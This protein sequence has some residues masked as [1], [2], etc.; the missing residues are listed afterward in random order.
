MCCSVLQ[1][2]AVQITSDI[3]Y[4][5]CCSQVLQ[6]VA[7]CC[8]M[9]QCV[10]VRCS[11]NYQRHPQQIISHCNIIQHMTATYCNTL[12]HTHCNTTYLRHPLQCVLQCFAVCCSVLQC[13]AVCCS[14]LQC[15]AV[16]CTATQRTCDILYRTYPKARPQ[17]WQR[18][19]CIHLQ[20]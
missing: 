14:V 18:F 19:C 1:C 13:V 11:A 10:A 6:Y 20:L 15:I 12:Q 4:S 2:V 3:L 9:L 5:V 7:V 17:Q 16:C 8:S